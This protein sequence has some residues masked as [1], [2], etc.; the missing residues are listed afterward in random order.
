MDTSISGTSFFF[1]FQR[2]STSSCRII[3]RHLHAFFGLVSRAVCVPYTILR[4]CMHAVSQSVRL[5]FVFSGSPCHTSLFFLGLPSAFRF[6]LTNKHSTE[7][8]VLFSYLQLYLTGLLQGTLPCACASLKLRYFVPQSCSCACCAIQ[9]HT[10]SS[11]SGSL[12]R[13]ISHPSQIRYWRH[14]YRT[15]LSHSH[16]HTHSLCFCHY[17]FSV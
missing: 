14:W 9:V 12:P 17:S 6:L 10:C 16:S 15:V 7:E 13:Q 2:Y 11:C 3:E 4:T 5:S 1:F 8:Y